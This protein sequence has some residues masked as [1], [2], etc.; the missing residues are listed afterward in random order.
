MGLIIVGAG[1]MATLGSPYPEMATIVVVVTS[2]V[3][4]FIGQGKVSGLPATRAAREDA[5]DAADDAAYAAGN[6]RWLGT[7]GVA[8]D[9]GR[10][11]VHLVAVG[12][13]ICSSL[14]YSAT[15]LVA[16]VFVCGYLGLLSMRSFLILSPLVPFSFRGI[17]SGVGLIFLAIVL[18]V[19]AVQLSIFVHPVLGPIV[20]APLAYGWHGVCQWLIPAWFQKKQEALE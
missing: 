2:I 9:A 1:L 3:L 7:R 10:P 14:S 5:R 6:L 11:A 15:G 20:L 8:D 13:T 4:M 19:I 12:G 18:F 16:S 17:V